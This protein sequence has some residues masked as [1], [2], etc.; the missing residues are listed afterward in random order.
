MFVYY[1]HIVT[2]EARRHVVPLEL[3]LKM[4]VDPHMGSENW[5]QLSNQSS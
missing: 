5:T 4:V 2:V 1:V 3:E